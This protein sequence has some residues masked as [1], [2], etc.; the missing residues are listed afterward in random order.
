MKGFCVAPVQHPLVHVPGE[1]TIAV[2]LAPGDEIECG[3][4]HF[5]Q[6]LSVGAVSTE[7][8]VIASANKPVA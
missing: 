3:D 4:E 2:V 8:P 5:A 6:L 7:K 1:E